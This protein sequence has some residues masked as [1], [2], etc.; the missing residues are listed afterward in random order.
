V[1][2]FARC[3]SDSA[4]IRPDA[5]ARQSKIKSAYQGRVPSRELTVPARKLQYVLPQ[6]DAEQLFHRGYN[7]F[8]VPV[9]AL[10][11]PGVSPA[12]VLVPDTLAFCGQVGKVRV[13]H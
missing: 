6:S 13:L 12:R 3:A 7:Q 5:R 1:E 9:V 8:S 4:F 2:R 10:A 11:Q